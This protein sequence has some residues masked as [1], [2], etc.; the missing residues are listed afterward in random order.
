MWL[1]LEQMLIGSIYHF[2]Q[3]LNFEAFLEQERNWCQQSGVDDEHLIHEEHVHCENWENRTPC[4]GHE[5]D[6]GRLLVSSDYS[7]Q[8]KLNCLDRTDQKRSDHRNYSN[9]CPA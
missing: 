9:D 6:I 1:H 3:T 8:Q 5:N 7:V 2:V 4:R